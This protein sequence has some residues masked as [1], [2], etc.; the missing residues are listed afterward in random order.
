MLV[1]TF[2]VRDQSLGSGSL[3]LSGP[4]S[5]SEMIMGALSQGYLGYDRQ[6]V[7]VLKSL[8]DGHDIQTVFQSKLSF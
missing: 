2:Q 5:F 4:V 7:K 1:C 3:K 6:P 8:N